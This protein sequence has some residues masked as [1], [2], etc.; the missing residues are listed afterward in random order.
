MM[1][2]SKDYEKIRK[3]YAE[4]LLSLSEVAALLAT[5]R[6]NITHYVNNG[7]LKPIRYI[8]TSS[9]GKGAPIFLK[10]EALANLRNRD[11]KFRRFHEEHIT[12]SLAKS[13]MK[14][15]GAQFLD[16]I[17]N[18]VIKEYPNIMR[19]N[20]ERGQQY[21]NLEEFKEYA[22]RF[23]I[24][25]EGLIPTR[26]V[27]YMLK[28]NGIDTDLLSFVRMNNIEEIYR[29]GDISIMAS[30]SEIPATYVYKSEKLRAGANFPIIFSNFR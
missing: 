11:G 1:D 19:N 26:A 16:D 3:E 20:R 7:V 13:I 17:Q 24:N 15:Y 30:P 4:E 27:E 5:T 23:G 6:Q 22:K 28:D 12:T 25:I 8:T 2:T 29:K 10:S 18:E 14:S 21:V 9:K